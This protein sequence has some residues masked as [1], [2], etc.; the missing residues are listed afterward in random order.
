MF[1]VGN[2]YDVNCKSFRNRERCLLKK[3]GRYLV[4]RKKLIVFNSFK[5]RW[6]VV[7]IIRIFVGVFFVF[8]KEAFIMG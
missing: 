2:R 1:I 7:D 4:F 6:N 3:G 8:D 5:G